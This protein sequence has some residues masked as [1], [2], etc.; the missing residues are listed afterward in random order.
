MS[1]NEQRPATERQIGVKEPERVEKGSY[2]HDTPP[3]NTNESKDRPGR[4]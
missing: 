4:R 2:E 1:E 3:K